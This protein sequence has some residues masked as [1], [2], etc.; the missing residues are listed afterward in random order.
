MFKPSCK[1]SCKR[2]S[3][4]TYCTALSITRTLQAHFCESNGRRNALMINEFGSFGKIVSEQNAIKKNAS[5]NCFSL[6]PPIGHHHACD[7]A[8]RSHMQL[9]NSTSCYRPNTNP[10]GSH[11]TCLACARADVPH[12]VSF[13]KV[14]LKGR[15]KCFPF[16]PANRPPSRV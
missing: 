11:A 8:C 2:S 5:R 3:A 16:R 15:R 7:S 1:P 6:W 13:T 14:A 10:H 4:R 12:L 9:P